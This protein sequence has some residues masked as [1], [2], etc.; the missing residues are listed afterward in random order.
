M[1]DV[2]VYVKVEGEGYIKAYA[3]LYPGMYIF[4]DPDEWDEQKSAEFMN[5]RRRGEGE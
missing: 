5:V 3:D 4:I 2:E 1:K